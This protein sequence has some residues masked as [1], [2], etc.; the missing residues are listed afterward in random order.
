[1]AVS[2]FCPSTL[3]QKNKTTELSQH[4]QLQDEQAISGFGLFD[5]ILVAAMAS[6]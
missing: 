1:M 2:D 3:V 6:L 4:L 5:R